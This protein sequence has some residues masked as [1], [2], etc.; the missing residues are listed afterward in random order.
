MREDEGLALIG[1]QEKL[2]GVAEA[3]VELGL[4]EA[5]GFWFF[6]GPRDC[7]LL[8]WGAHYTAESAAC[9]AGRGSRKTRVPGIAFAGSLDPASTACE[10]RSRESD[11]PPPTMC[12]S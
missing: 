2:F 6:H 5:R 7:F 8:V 3:C 11:E 4:G 1:G 12:T 9:A 10:T